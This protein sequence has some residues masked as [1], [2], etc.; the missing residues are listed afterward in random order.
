MPSILFVAMSESVH[1]ARWISQ[2]ADQG[3][4]VYLFPVYRAE[5]HPS[6]RNLTLFG[7]DPIRPRNLDS[8][9]RYKRWSSLYLYRDYIESRIKHRPTLYKE[10]A[11]AKVI[12]H[13]KPDLIHALE[14]QH[15]AYLTMGAKKLISMPFPKWIATNWGSD[16]YLFG[17]LVAHKPKIQEVLENCDYYSAEC[18]RD[19]ELARQMGYTGEV[20]P[21]LPNGGGYDLDHI[22]TLRQAV[23]AISERKIIALKGYQTWAGRALV[24]LNALRLCADQ[25]SGYEVIVYAAGEEV[26]IAAE[27]FGQETGIPVTILPQTSHEEILK[28]HGR[29]RI[30]IG[31]SIS[32]AISTSLLESIAMGSFPI[33]SGTA[34][35]NEWI[36][37]GQSGFIVPPEDP[38]KIA[39]AIRRALMDDALVNQAA[40][41]NARMVRK[42]LDNSKVQ[43]QVIEM[44]LG[45]IK[46]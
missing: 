46:P 17:R 8:S 3:W 9:V 26:Q 23:A 45:I 14:F 30:S 34:C 2:I 16:I 40:E 32:D 28:L 33:Q 38:Y 37:D 13:I 15:S 10:I 5:P 21:V 35:A 27:L 11:L 29:A 18:Q 39:E 42:R 22:L 6:L 20:L 7:S 19:V 12:Q 41:I 1:T 31:L 4:D 36:A 24:G 44:Y 25:L 43:S